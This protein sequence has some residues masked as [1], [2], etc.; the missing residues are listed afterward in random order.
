MANRYIVALALALLEN[1][2]RTDHLTWTSESDGSVVADVGDFSI[3]VWYRDS[4][5]LEDTT[6]Y[7]IGLM[8]AGGTIID[9]VND[10]DLRPLEKTSW[11]LMNNLYST[12]RARAEGVDDAVR[13][14]LTKLNIDYAEA[15]AR[16]DDQGGDQPEDQDEIPF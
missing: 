5:E 7:Y 16:V 6:D 4:Q 15:L 3:V 13:S 11:S 1:P 14:V 12:G 8:D 9:Q 10:D 2:T